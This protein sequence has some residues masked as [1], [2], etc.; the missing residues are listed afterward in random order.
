M[1]GEDYGQAPRVQACAALA[2]ALHTQL[3]LWFQATQLPPAPPHQEG[4]AMLSTSHPESWAL[5]AQ[6]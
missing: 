3:I 2:R 4:P 1:A 6:H 5:S